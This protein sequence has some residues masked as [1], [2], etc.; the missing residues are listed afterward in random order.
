[1]RPAT[2]VIRAAL[3]R[4]AATMSLREIGRQAGIDV[5]QLSRFRSGERQLTTG[6]G[7]DRLIAFLGLAVTK[8]G[9]KR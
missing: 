5:A 1:M 6:D 8:K 9:R 7:L 3:V 4:R 2:E